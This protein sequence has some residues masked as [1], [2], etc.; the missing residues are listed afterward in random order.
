MAWRTALRNASTTSLGTNA[1]GGLILSLVQVV[2]VL[3]RYSKRVSH[4]SMPTSFN[5]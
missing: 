4:A 2:Q 5:A 1:L 3:I